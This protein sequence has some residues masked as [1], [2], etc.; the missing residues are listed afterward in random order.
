ML[1][2]ASKDATKRAEMI[3][4][5]AGSKLGNLSHAHI[6]DMKITPLYSNGVDYYD[7]YGYRLGNDIASLKKEVSVVLYCTFEIK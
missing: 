2:E 6:S 7:G 4:E 1:A 3:A 5:N